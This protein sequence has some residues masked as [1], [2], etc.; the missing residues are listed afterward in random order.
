MR[1]VNVS[2]HYGL[3]IYPRDNILTK[4]TLGQVIN[5]VRHEQQFFLLAS[6]DIM[7]RQ[8]AAISEREY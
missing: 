5:P 8:R 2:H 6:I 1:A 7:E 3:S 4:L